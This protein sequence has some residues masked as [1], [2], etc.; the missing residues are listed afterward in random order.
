ME[1]KRMEQVNLE[2]AIEKSCN[3]AFVHMSEEI[4]KGKLA[5]L[6]GDSDV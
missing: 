1:E 6:A 2:Q 4:N 3:C 5:S